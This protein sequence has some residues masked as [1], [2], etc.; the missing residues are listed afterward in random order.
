MSK[1]YI[2]NIAGSDPVVATDEGAI[3]R[4]LDDLH[5]GDLID[6]Y[7]INNG[8]RIKYETNTGQELDVVAYETEY[9]R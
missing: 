2:V 5:D 1:V 6:S 8:F 7:A 9:Y 4:G 3:Y